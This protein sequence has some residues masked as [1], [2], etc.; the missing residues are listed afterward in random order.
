MI[1]TAP[2]AC[3]SS[4]G[5]TRWPA[6]RGDAAH[7]PAAAHA[8]LGERRRSPS[9][10]ELVL[11]AI[12]GVDAEGS[13]R[14]RA[15]RSSSRRRSPASACCS[16]ASPRAPSTGRSGSSRITEGS[17]ELAL[18]VTVRVLAI[19][20]PAVA[21]L[22][23]RRPHRPRRRARAGRAAPEPIRA[24]R[25][26]RRCDSSACSWRTGARW[27]WRAGRA[28]SAITACI[29][30]FATMAFALLVLSIR[31]GSKLATAM[32]A[33]GFGSDHPRTWARESR[34][35]WPD[36]AL[37]CIAVG[38]RGARDRLRGLGGH[39]HAGV[40]VSGESARAVRPRPRPRHPRCDSCSSD[41]VPRAR[42]SWRSTARAVRARA[43]SP[44][45]S[46]AA[47]PGPA[48]ELV[49]LDDV[50][51]GWTG[52]EPAGA[53]ARARARRPP[54]ARR[55]RAVAAMG[56]AGRPGRLDRAEQAG[57][58]AH[59]RGLRGIRR[60]GAR[61]DAVARVGRGVD[62]V[63][64]SDGR[65]NAMPGRSIRTGTCGSASGAGTSRRTA[66][67]TPCRRARAR[68]DA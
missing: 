42:R 25:A 13:R 15:G 44:T 41:V 11:F 7:D 64:A 56:L 12:A 36:A 49:R 68:A 33:R 50:Y 60:D 35:G 40:G 52:L 37:L 34:V 66:L 19:A 9:A 23:E 58:G 18:A 57:P 10:C 2:R 26:R 48:P 17:L 63:C 51:P 59:R 53:A 16:T 45:R 38:H 31:R 62:R 5:S 20:L 4:T 14:A 29:R 65:S 28:A 21:A 61:L 47:W 8:R 54:R 24:R 67:R 1:A 6:R 55:G 46:C 43:R 30:R 27:R 3:T 32:E 39:L 22:H